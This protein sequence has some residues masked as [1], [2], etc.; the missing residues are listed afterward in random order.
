MNNL[1]SVIIEGT[2]KTKKSC[3]G[4][5]DISLSVLR[6]STAGKEENVFCVRTTGVIAERCDD[7]CKEGTGMRVVGRLQQ[8]DNGV[9]VF[10]EHVEFKP[11]R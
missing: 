11:A 9:V 8:T 4:G 7:R 5:L 1:N 6:F 10:A 3:Q 2:V